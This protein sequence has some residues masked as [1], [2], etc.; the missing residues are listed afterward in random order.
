[1]MKEGMTE[2]GKIT[3]PVAAQVENQ[4]LLV[5]E[6]EAIIQPQPGKMCLQE[7][8]KRKPPL[9]RRGN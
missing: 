1:M 4:G 2:S 8:K 9:D 6:K 3:A 5:A 7:K